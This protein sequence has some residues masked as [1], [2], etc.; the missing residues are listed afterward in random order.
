M[1]K[2]NCNSSTLK[3]CVYRFFKFND[4]KI[5]RFINLQFYRKLKLN[6]CIMTEK[7]TVGISVEAIDKAKVHIVKKK[8]K[9]KSLTDFMDKATDNLIASDNDNDSESTE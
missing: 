6:G 4:S 3:N 8:E 5:K 1:D 9:Y 7:T 2:R